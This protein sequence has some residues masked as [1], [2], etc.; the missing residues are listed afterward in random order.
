MDLM[1]MHRSCSSLRVSVKRVSPARAE[2]MIPALHTRESVSVDLPW[3]TWAITDMFLMLAFLSM[4]ARIW[5]TV[6]F[7]LR[8]ERRGAQRVRKR[9]RQFRI[10]HKSLP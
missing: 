6:K 8:E 4:M 5:S 9:L 7:T 1:V 10:C 2:A 3:S